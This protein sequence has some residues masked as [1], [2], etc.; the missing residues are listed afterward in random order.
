[1]KKEKRKINARHLTYLNFFPHIV[2]EG[3]NGSQYQE[4]HISSL[5]IGNVIFDQIN[6]C[7]HDEADLR[8]N[9]TNQKKPFKHIYEFLKK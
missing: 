7:I 4:D 8:L 3:D 9:H 6:P 2:V 1:M 5:K